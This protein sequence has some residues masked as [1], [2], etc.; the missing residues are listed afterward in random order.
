MLN[1]NCAF[2]STLKNMSVK[3][4]GCHGSFKGGENFLLQSKATTNK[5]QSEKNDSMIL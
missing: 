3:K 4:M 2:G 5:V 1:K